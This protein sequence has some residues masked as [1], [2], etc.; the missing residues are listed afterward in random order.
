MRIFVL[1]KGGLVLW[2]G[3][4]FGENVDRKKTFF[5]DFDPIFGLN[6]IYIH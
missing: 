5:A 4:F 1:I 2:C 3:R 6:I